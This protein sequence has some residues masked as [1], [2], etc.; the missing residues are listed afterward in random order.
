MPSSRKVFQLINLLDERMMLRLTLKCI[1]RL[2]QASTNEDIDVFSLLV[3]IYKFFKL[4]PPE[5]LVVNKL[6]IIGWNSEFERIRILFQVDEIYN[7]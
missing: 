2:I 5:N 6:L 4:H 1:E 3:E 7:R